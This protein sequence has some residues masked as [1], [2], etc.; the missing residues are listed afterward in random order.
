MKKITAALLLAGLFGAVS[1]QASVVEFNAGKALTTTNWSDTLS[2]GKFDTKLGTLTSIKFELNGTV[3]GIGRA[4]SLDGA[5][6]NVTLTLGSLLTLQRPDGSTLVVANPVFST[7][8]QFSAFDGGID[9][10]GSSGASTGQVSNSGSNAFT[11]FNA[12]DFAA[13]S[14]AGGGGI[15]LKLTA[16]GNS[17]ANGAGNLI[18]TFNTAAAGDV[19]V[20]YEYTAAAPV[21]EPE[22]YGML[23]LGMGVLGLARRRANKN[24]AA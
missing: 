24:K 7:G 5:A 23:L 11:S 1:A 2:F 13:F 6:S 9:F 19:K 18:S 3:A 12:N 22:T 10:A 14:A 15:G 17:S 21:P 4:E 20:V 16:M 8:Y